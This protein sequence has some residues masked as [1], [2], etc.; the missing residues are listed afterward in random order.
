[1]IYGVVLHASNLKVG[2]VVRSMHGQCVKDPTFQALFMPDDQDKPIHERRRIA[3]TAGWRNPPVGGPNDFRQ[4]YDVMTVYRVTAD[5]V[6][7]VRPYFHVNNDGTVGACGVEH[8]DNCGR[9]AGGWWYEL[10]G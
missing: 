2:D 7:F 6:S 9:D 4:G 8:V 10:L 5:H 1:M 3:N